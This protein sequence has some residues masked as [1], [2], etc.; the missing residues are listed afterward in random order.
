MDF[1]VVPVLGLGGGKDLMACDLA[2]A[3][4]K[5]GLKTGRE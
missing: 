2:H 5:C 4:P 3:G 1:I